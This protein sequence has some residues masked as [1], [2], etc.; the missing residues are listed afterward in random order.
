MDLKN[1]VEWNATQRAIFRLALHPNFDVPNIRDSSFN[2]F[3]GYKT[4]IRVNTIQLRSDDS[5]KELNLQKRKCRFEFE[6]DNL[7]LFNSYSR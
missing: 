6:H 4:T 7:K 3:A 1:G 2:L 5:V